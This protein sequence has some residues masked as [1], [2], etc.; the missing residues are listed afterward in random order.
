MKRRLARLA[1]VPCLLGLVW[2]SPAAQAP[3]LSRFTPAL[4]RNL[5]ENIIAF[6][7]P[8]SIDRL[9]GG[10]IVDFDASGTFKGEAAKM[11]VSQA[12][13]VWLSARLLRAGY[14]DAEMRAAADQG[15]RFLMTHMWDRQN[16]GFFWEVDRAGARVVHANKHLYGQAFGLYALSEYFLA[17]RDPQALADARALFDL[18]EAKAHDKVYGG[19]VEFFAPDW[20][21]PP[22]DAKPY[23]GGSEPGQKLM[24]THL[25]LLEAF[26]TFYRASELPLARERLLEL[27]AIQSNAVVRKNVGAC[28]DQYARDWTPLL[29]ERTARAS[30]GHDLENIWL[31]VD[32]IDAAGVSNY[33]YLDLYRQLFSYSLTYGYDKEQGGFFDDGPLGKPADRRDKT[34]W[35]QAEA[36]VSALTMFQLTNDVAYANVF[37]KTL[38]WVNTRQTDWAVGEW[39]PTVTPS[40]ETRGDKAQ[41]WK[42]GY[43]QGRAMIESLRLLEPRRAVNRR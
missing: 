33:P 22:A 15:Y 7:Y 11:I 37:T 8:R 2:T 20:S 27:I 38:E 41:R 29:N 39:F 32:A 25:H 40:G 19:Y 3:D 23:L 1:L 34:W 5:R 42:A 43:H 28:T 21:P 4:Q 24:N 12:R 16:G 35:V 14:G 13:M 10:F 30:Y 18:L 17:T 31:L 26:T 9:H 36:L 6:W